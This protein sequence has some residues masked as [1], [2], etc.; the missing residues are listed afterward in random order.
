MPAET[1]TTPRHPSTSDR[2]QTEPTPAPVLLRLPEIR[3]SIG[4]IPAVP[5]ATARAT[6]SVP[7]SSDAQFPPSL[8]TRLQASLGMAVSR[9]SRL[10]EGYGKLLVIAM[11]LV[12]IALVLGVLPWTRPDDAA[13]EAPETPVEWEQT[14]DAPSEGGP[15]IVFGGEDDTE[16][17]P[18]GEPW[19]GDGLAA[20]ADT[21]M[22]VEATP[23]LLQVNPQ[24]VPTAEE[25]GPLIGP[26]NSAMSE[27]SPSAPS[28]DF[29]ALQKK[30]EVLADEPARADNV[31]P[32]LDIATAGPQ[33]V[34]PMTRN[35]A[36]PNTVTPPNM[37]AAEN[38]TQAELNHIPAPTNVDV[39]YRDTG[40]PKFA[41]PTMQSQRDSRSASRNQPS[42][43][44]GGRTGSRSS[45]TQRHERSGSG[46]Y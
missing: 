23:Q 4:Q 19:L 43:T 13:P 12:L 31:A 33:T 30:A 24:V 41:P 18:S 28:L 21:T 35:V 42:G 27:S 8:W 1:V 9:A 15:S 10:T 45:E 5:T 40:F 46:L 22:Q 17:A 6:E 37:G 44:T 7:V 32:S 3:A 20:D 34:G 25:V 14:V 29:A 16:S 36:P 2:S 11:V 39:L 38:P 26:A